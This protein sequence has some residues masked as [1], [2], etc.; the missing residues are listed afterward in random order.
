VAF[1]FF[2]GKSYVYIFQG[3]RDTADLI[4]VQT[5]LGKGSG[6]IGFQVQP[7]EKGDT[8]TV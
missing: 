6:Y 8:I 2:I 4:Y 1:C 3:S 5:W 7:V